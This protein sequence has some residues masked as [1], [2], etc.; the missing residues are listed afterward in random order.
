[1]SEEKKKMGRPRK[2]EDEKDFEQL[3][4]LMRLN[5]TLEDT[6]AFF[7]C[8]A[9]TIEETIRKHFDLTFR[10]FREQN[11]VHTRLELVRSAIRKSEKSDI[12]HKY[13]L[14]NLCK[15]GEKQTVELEGN[16]EKPIAV[17]QV[18]LEERLKLLMGDND[19]GNSNTD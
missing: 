10:E 4:A 3:K 9:T 2:F 7:Q 11:M 16:Q 17:K 12:M 1:M 13:C 15:W 18:D 14:A 8:G 6:A 19:S 5:P